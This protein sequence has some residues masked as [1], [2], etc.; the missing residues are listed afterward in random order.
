MNTPLINRRA[1]LKTGL[2]GAFSL[3]VAG[4]AADGPTPTP[5]RTPTIGIATFGFPKFSNAELAR[6]LADAGISTI[7][8]FLSQ[9][10]SNFWRYNGRSDLSGL[11]AERCREI[12][13]TY[14]NAG[15]GI[16]SL[17]VYTNLIHP[18]PAERKA[19]L[20]YFEDMM[21]VGRHMGVRTFITEAGH[22]QP[23]KPQAVEYHFQQSVWEQMVATGKDLAG[24]AERHD[25][26][27]LLE[28]FFRGFLTSAKR[29]RLFLEAVGSPR[30]RALLDPANLLEVNDLDE[31][32]DQLGD[33]IDCLHAKDRKLHVD[34]G[35]PA[36]QGDL[37]YVRF[38]R[39]A[40]ER[41]P[42]APFILEYVGAENYRA[43][44]EHL[45]EALRRA[46][47]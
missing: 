30:L 1:A 35:V 41:T 20:D 21:V 42:D 3:P 46:R 32:F 29:T 24:L 16:H 6:E 36:G 25:S 13:E 4:R 12:A 34:R 8:L 45:R 31:M 5:E 38:A 23:E 43:A 14:R 10:D 27:V 33:H 47:E 28:P 19:N 44:R 2:A 18:D 9:T 17:G 26:V 15:V 40:A 7:Q 37:D 11:T 22:H 39:L